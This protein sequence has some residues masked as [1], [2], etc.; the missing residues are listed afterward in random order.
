[1]LSIASK[2]FYVYEDPRIAEV[3]GFTALANCGGCGYTGCSAAAAAVVAGKAS[4]RVCVVADEESAI[5]IAGVMGIDPGTAE[6]ILSYNTC[7]GG[8]RADDKYFYM[9]INSCQGLATLYG[10]KRECEVGCLG[11]G[12][13]VKACIFDAIKMGPEGFPVVNEIKCVGCGACEKV[14]PKDIL[15][16]KTMS[17]RLLHLNQ[18][19]DRIAPCQQTCPAEIDIPKYIAQINEGDYEGAV[20]TIRERNPLLLSCGRVCPHPCEDKC[21]RGIEDEP[22]SINQMKRFVADYEMNSGRRF[23]IPCAPST[24]KKIAVVGGGPAGLSC[25]YFLRRV[26][27]DVTIL[28]A[29]PLLGGMIRYGIP[30]YRLPKEVLAW[31]IQGILDLG[32]EHKPNVMLGRDFDVES[33]MKDG[34][35]AVFLGI[36]AW[37]DYNLGVEGENLKGCYTGIDFLTKFALWQQGDGAE[38]QPFFGQKCVVIG[39]GNTAIDC[40]RTLVR[41]GSEEVSIVYRRT[42]KEM[43]A[44]M[45]EIEAAEHEGIQFTFLAAPTRVIGD[46]AGNVTG[47]EYL[48]MELGEPDASGRRRPVPIEGSETTIEI[49]MLITAIGQGPDVFFKDE[50]KLLSEDLNLTRWN[51]IDSADP[52]ALQSSIPYIFTGGDAATGAALVVDAIGGGRRA[53]RSI[54]MYITGEEITPPPKTLFADNIPISIFDS[55]EGIEKSARTKMPELPVDE[56]I[57]SFVEADLV[58][59]EEEARYESNRCLQCCLICYNKDV[60]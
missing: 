24:D 43:P 42:R 32:I 47:L 25:A 45:V 52:V 22:V 50:S 21:R 12:D 14:C 44:N 19:D 56:R 29:M 59:T 6:A 2:V 26:G 30:E 17:Q 16:I 40:V 33:L 35:D 38:E 57:K 46:E 10:G 39:G 8:N 58:I 53:A 5:N 37:K 48:K 49:D 7:T 54:H 55:V 13:C 20:N 18:F 36:G 1:M 3:E 41:L 28:D 60:D 9:G 4:P 51:T 23:P 31:E 27:H 15:E 11:L 34:Y